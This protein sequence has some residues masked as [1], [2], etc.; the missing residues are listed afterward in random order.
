[1]SFKKILL[2]TLL[3]YWWVY[4]ASATYCKTMKYAHMC[5]V[6]PL[7]IEQPHLCTLKINLHKKWYFMKLVIPLHSLYRSIHT[8]DESKFTQN[9]VC[10]HLCCELTPVFRFFSATLHAFMFWK[11]FP[12]CPH[13]LS[14]YY[15]NVTLR[16]Q[17]THFYFQNYH[18]MPLAANQLLEAISLGPIWKLVK[19]KPNFTF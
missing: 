7:D 4:Y 5:L 10:F 13:I 16:F 12:Q 11:I 9:R 15:Y 1:M 18:V 3:F 6:I 17:G 8:K 14:I 2:P 19:F